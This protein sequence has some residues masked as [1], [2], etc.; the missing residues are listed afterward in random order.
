MMPENVLFPSIHMMECLGIHE[1][2]LI[3]KKGLCMIYFGREMRQY[4]IMKNFVK[5]VIKEIK[6]WQRKKLSGGMLVLIYNNALDKTF[7]RK[8]KHRWDDPS[9]I[10]KWFANGTYELS[11]MGGELLEKRING[12]RL[13][14]YILRIMSSSLNVIS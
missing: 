7:Q 8:L 4:V 13:K 2:V 9:V 12:V 1:N 6:N 14:P 10:H 3:Y 11:P 5:S